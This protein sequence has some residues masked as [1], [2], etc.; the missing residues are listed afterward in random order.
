MPLTAFFPPAQ[1]MLRRLPGVTEDNV[2]RLLGRIHCIADLATMKEAELRPVM[3]SAN[4]RKLRRFL[5]AADM[6]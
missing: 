5:D 6:L 1:D 3:G 2:P 4:A